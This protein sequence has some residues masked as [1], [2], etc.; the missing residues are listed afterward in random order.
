MGGVAL[1]ALA[2]LLICSLIGGSVGTVLLDREEGA[3]Q[4]PDAAE[5]RGNGFER[6]L[7]E[8][9]A[10]NPNDASAMASLANLLA[11]V[12]EREEAIDWYER[13]LAVAPEDRQVRL[14]FATTLADAGKRADAEVQFG[15]LI[16]ADPANLDPTFYLAELYATWD[17]ARTAEAVALY[18]AVVARAPDAYFLRGRAGEALARL[19]GGGSPEASPTS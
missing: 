14:D 13:S 9:I 12:G 1:G 5:E 17:P 3:E 4:E 18:R 15:R 2:A 10:T 7:R 6:S 16:E 11:T 19:N 8:A